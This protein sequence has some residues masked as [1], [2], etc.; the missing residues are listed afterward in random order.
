MTL[1][2]S[3]DVLGWTILAGAA[4][5]ML[6]HKLEIPPLATLAVGALVMA[7]VYL[8]VNFRKPR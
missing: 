6:A 1:P 4:A 5:W 8:P 2:S 7:L 3:K